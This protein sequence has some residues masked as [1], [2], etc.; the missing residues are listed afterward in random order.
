MSVCNKREYVSNRD[1]TYNN[2]KSVSDKRDVSFSFYVNKYIVGLTILLLVG[3]PGAGV[4]ASKTKSG[5]A[6]VIW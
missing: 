4:V 3:G 6:L 2:H 5:L 1:V